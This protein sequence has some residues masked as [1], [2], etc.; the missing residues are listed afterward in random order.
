MTIT[1]PTGATQPSGFGQRVRVTGYALE[2]VLWFPVLL[3]AFVVTVV[4]A[5]LSAIVVGLPI[6]QV[7]LFLTRSAADRHRTLANRITGAAMPDPHRPVPEAGWLVRLRARAED[8]MTW[9]ELLWTLVA[10]TVGFTLALTVFLLFVTVVGGLVWWFAA[11]A[12]MGLRATIDRAL[13]YYARSEQLEVRVA[14][15]TETRAEAV[16]HST[17]ELRR[18]ERDLHD[19]AQARLVALSMTLGVADDIYEQDAELARKMINDARFTTQAALSD[20][21]S[22]VRSIH[23][24]V[25]ADRGLAGAV[26]SLAIDMAVPVETTIELTGRPP[27]SVET[28]VYFAIAEALANVGKHAGAAHAWITLHHKPTPEAGQTSGQLRV[29][30]GD[31]GNGG[32]DPGRGTGMRGVAT[33]LAAFDGRMWV[34]SPAGGPTLITLEVPCDL[35]SPR[36]SPSSGSA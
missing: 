12:L 3:I 31:D 35:S 5:G 9:R 10:A 32:A 8:P 30:V 11:P 28:A 16:D 23:P 4:G 33:R 25:L 14:Q 21:R 13:L 6:F 1:S 27:A 36:T 29:V 22:V 7:G 20:L 15:L 26:E 2:Q 34:S 24:P 19:G 18:I 17:I